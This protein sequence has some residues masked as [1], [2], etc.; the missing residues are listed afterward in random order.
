M[1][2]EWAV[3]VVPVVGMG[4]AA[5]AV[6]RECSEVYRLHQSRNHPILSDVICYL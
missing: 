4:T 3:T 1:W 2:L 5:P 6:K